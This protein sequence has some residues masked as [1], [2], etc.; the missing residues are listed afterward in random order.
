MV[1]SPTDDTDEKCPRWDSN[2]HSMDFE[3]ISSAVGIRGRGR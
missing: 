1:A 2:P 3:A